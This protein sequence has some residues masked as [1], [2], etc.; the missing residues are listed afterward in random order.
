[1]Y[2]ANTLSSPHNEMQ[3]EPSKNA[4][5]QIILPETIRAFLKAA[6]KKPN[7]SNKIKGKSMILT[8]IKEE[9]EERAKERESR[10]KKKKYVARKVKESSSSEFGKEP[11]Y[12]NCS[13]WEIEDEK[14]SFRN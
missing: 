6:P 5:R 2:R 11:D 13:E 4:N 3:P 10:A 9:L 14:N 7:A 1:M 8:P 12:E